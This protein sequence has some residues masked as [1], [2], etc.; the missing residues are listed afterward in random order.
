MSSKVWDKKSYPLPNLNG[1]TADIWEWISSFTH[2]SWD[3]SSTMLVKRGPCVIVYMFKWRSRKVTCWH[4]SISL[5][6]DRGLGSHA[7]VNFRNNGKYLSLNITDS[8]FHE[9]CR[10]FDVFFA[11]VITVSCDLFTHNIA[12]CLIDTATIIWP[13]DIG[14]IILKR[15]PG[16]QMRATQQLWYLFDKRD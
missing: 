8:T 16:F 4:L 2:P 3:W 1:C 13:P 7:S 15:T 10:W 6:F 11:A 5:N 12:G 14:E 9:T